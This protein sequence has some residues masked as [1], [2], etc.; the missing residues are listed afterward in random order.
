M[1]GLLVRIA[2]WYHTLGCRRVVMS[3][4]GVRGIGVA[5]GDRGR[6]ECRVA[7]ER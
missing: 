4:D 7:L 3:S 2:G 1:V 5:R 6:G